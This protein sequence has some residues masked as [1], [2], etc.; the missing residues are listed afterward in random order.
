LAISAPYILYSYIRHSGVL[1]IKKGVK[2]V[3]N[4]TAMLD[5]FTGG[6]LQFGIF[7]KKIE[8]SLFGAAVLYDL[9]PPTIF[10][11]GCQDFCFKRFSS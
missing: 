7:L 11:I 6:I 2:Y 1:S 9:K 5:S 10:L 8:F 3:A 4:R